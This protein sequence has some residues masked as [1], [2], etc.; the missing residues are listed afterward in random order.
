M[1][2]PLAPAG[3]VRADPVDLQLLVVERGIS[4]F[5]QANGDEKGRVRK[6]GDRPVGHACVRAG[7]ETTL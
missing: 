4:R 6:A 1:V 7:G 3:L 5:A 2:L